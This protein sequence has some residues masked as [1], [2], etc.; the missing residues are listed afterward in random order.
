MVV[1]YVA[2]ADTWKCIRY[3]V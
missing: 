2:N 3:C 1:Y